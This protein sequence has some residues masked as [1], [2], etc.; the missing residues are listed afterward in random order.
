MQEREYDKFFENEPKLTDITDPKA[1]I[2]PNNDELEQ[3]VKEKRFEEAKQLIK[4]NETSF[5]EDLKNK[6]LKFIQEQRQKGT[7][8]RTI[9]RL[10]KKKFGII[11]LS[12]N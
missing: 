2:N 8:E 10:V 4:E 6:I 3:L 7:R 5:P 9:R 12:N 11:V 1:W